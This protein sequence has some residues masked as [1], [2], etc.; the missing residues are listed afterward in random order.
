MSHAEVREALAPIRTA[1]TVNSLTEDIHE[2]GMQLAE[3][4]QL[5]VYDA[6][7]VASALAAGC[8]TLLTEDLQSGQLFDQELRVY[9]PFVDRQ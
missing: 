9:N 1:C 6:M 4:Y 8:K 3:R 7:I 5:S 2:F